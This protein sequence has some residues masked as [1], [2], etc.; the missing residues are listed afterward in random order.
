MANVAEVKTVISKGSIFIVRKSSKTVRQSR[1]ELFHAASHRLGHSLFRRW[2][3]TQQAVEGISVLAE[4]QEK[5]LARTFHTRRSRRRE[6]ADG[7]GVC[8]GPPP[9]V[10]G[11]GL[12]VLQSG[13]EKKQ[14]S[15]DGRD[16]S[17]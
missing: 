16:Q 11:Y 8:K 10:G 15:S 17:S 14:V 1:P 5:T 4:H 3:W 9:Y 13:C 7:L 6:E 12:L 2:L